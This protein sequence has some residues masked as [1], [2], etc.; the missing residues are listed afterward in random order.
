MTSSPRVP[1]I[2]SGVMRNRE[3]ME[4]NTRT[5]TCT[6]A[7]TRMRTHMHARTHTRTHTH[8]HTHACTHAHTH[9]HMHAH[10]RMYTLWL[11]SPTEL[12]YLICRTIIQS[13]MIAFLVF[14]VLM[15]FPEGTWLL[16]LL[17][18]KRT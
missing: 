17:W 3:G 7:H 1:D 11:I 6:P 2:R 15:S 4:S 14:G 5:H 18:L 16:F 13:E 12:G 9:T 10:T 8:V